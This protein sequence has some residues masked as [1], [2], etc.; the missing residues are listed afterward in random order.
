MTSRS[1]G[2]ADASDRLIARAR[3]DGRLVTVAELASWLQVDPSYV[4]E[5]ADEL[6]AMRLGTGPKA[7]LRFDLEDVRQRISCEAG[8]ESVRPD[9]ASQAASR[10][11]RRRPLG[12]TVPLLPIRGKISAQNGAGKVA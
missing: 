7:R 3:A 8:R 11:R 4:Y 5:H 9:A 2:R 6:G 1:S 10:R 12:T